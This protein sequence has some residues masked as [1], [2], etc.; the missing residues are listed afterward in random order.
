MK[1]V[2]YTVLTGGYE[3]L[4]Q[5]SVIDK[6]ITYICFSNDIKEKKSESGK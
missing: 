2:I 6:D 5:P 1:I 3:K 4:I